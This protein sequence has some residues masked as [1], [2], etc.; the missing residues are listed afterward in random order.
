MEKRQEECVAVQYT[1][2]VAFPWFLCISLCIVLFSSPPIAHAD[3]FPIIGTLHVGEHPE[4][5][6]VDIQTHI[7]YIA[8]EFPGVI[9]GFDPIRGI[10]RWRVPVGNTATDVQV[11]STSHHVYATTTS[12]STQ[13]SM[14]FIL[15]GATGHMLFTIPVDFGDNAIVLDEQRQRLYVAGPESGVIDA[16]SF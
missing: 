6:A 9:V 5:L 2:L 12:F 13:Q 3:G 4:A 8:D 16:F 7:L 1:L 14:L 11:D 15:D 10:V